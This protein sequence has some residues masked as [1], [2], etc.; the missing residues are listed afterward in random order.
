MSNQYMMTGYPGFI[1]GRLSVHWLRGIPLLPLSFS[2]SESIGEGPRVD[3]SGREGS[4]LGGRYHPGGSGTVGGR[5][6]CAAGE[7]HPFLSSGGDL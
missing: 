2:S 7:H 4:S 3:G 1:A 5:T 6:A